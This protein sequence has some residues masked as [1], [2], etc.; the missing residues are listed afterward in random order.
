MTPPVPVRQEA[1]T[2]IRVREADHPPQNRR[3]PRP[4]RPRHHTQTRPPLLYPLHHLVHF[5][6][7][8]REPG[9]FLEAVTTA[10]R[11]QQV[12]DHRLGR[13]GVVQR[14]GEHPPG[15]S[16]GPEVRRLRPA[17]P[18]LQYGVAHV[19][20]PD[21]LVVHGPPHPQHLRVGAVGQY[22]AQPLPE[23]AVP[24]LL[25]RQARCDDADPHPPCRLRLSHDQRRQ[26]VRRDP[27][28]REAG[29]EDEQ[30]LVGA[31]LRAGEYDIDEGDAVARVRAAVRAQKP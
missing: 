11:P 4:R 24:R 30:E 14:V 9:L 23:E 28:A 2:L 19:V 1:M 7:A 26:V 13:P 15:A 5:R 20:A 6:R 16:P 29:V 17:A 22:L 3:L 27:V 21:V 18:L 25:R 31:R 12:L 10:R 8:P